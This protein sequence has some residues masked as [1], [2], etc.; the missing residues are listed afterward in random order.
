MKYALPY[1]PIS[2]I[3]WKRLVILGMAYHHVNPNIN[4]NPTSQNSTKFRKNKTDEKTTHSR[5]NRTIQ[6]EQKRSH[7]QPQH[8]AED[9]N[10]GEIFVLVLHAI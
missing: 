8:Q 9:S 6:R 5:K 4:P 1:H 10:G 2:S 3:E 7:A